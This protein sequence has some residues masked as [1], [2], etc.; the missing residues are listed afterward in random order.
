MYQRSTNYGNYA[1][2]VMAGDGRSKPSPWS[3][4][5][6]ESDLAAHAAST[7]PLRM[8]VVE[9]GVGEFVVTVA[10]D[11][12]ITDARFVAA[13]VLAEDIPSSSGTSYLPYHAKTFMTPYLR[14]PLTV[15][16]GDS[17]E[18]DVSFSVAPTW[19]YEDMGVAAWVQID[20]GS[21][22]S[23]APDLPEIHGVL[24]AAFAPASATGVAEGQ[25]ARCHLAAP[26]PNPSRGSVCFSINAESS[27]HLRL[28]V[29]DLTGRRVA[30]LLDGAVGEGLHA[31]EWD[32]RNQHG[33][34]CAS[35]VYFAH[36]SRGG[37]P[38]GSRKLVLI[39]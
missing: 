13:A 3:V 10:A 11:D 16:S 33:A 35:G 6:M 7:S 4:S 34:S 32:G 38:V 23:S 5:D 19:S 36:L 20:G 29:Y 1:T 17:L 15:S 27:E 31:I 39:R 24:Q 2:P 9:L 28:A 8:K 18:F 30:V 37:T 21:N 26:V 25:V 14:T 22:P 12:D